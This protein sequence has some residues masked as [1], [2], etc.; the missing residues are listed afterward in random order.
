MDD[1]KLIIPQADRVGARLLL[2]TE[3][4]RVNLAVV[5]PSYPPTFYCQVELELDDEA[6]FFAAV[7][8]RLHLGN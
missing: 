4:D 7:A 8:E 5:P 3:K 6:G 1:F 2:T